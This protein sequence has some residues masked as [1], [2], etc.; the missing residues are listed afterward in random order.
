MHHQWWCNVDQF[1]L[2]KCTFT[3]SKVDFHPQ[4]EKGTGKEERVRG[5]GKYWL[6]DVVFSFFLLKIAWLVWCNWRIAWFVPQ[7]QMIICSDFQYISC[8]PP[9]HHHGGEREVMHSTI[10][11]CTSGVICSKSPLHQSKLGCF[12]FFSFST[13]VFFLILLVIFS[14]SLTLNV[15]DPYSIQH[16]QTAEFDCFFGFGLPNSAVYYLVVQDGVT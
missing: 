3:T 10:R 14:A 5:L 12:F 16:L 2:T 8:E 9:L 11:R 4:E 15:D 7:C 13:F 1:G 6:G